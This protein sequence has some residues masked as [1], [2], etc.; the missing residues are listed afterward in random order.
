MT[1]EQK[2]AQRIYDRM[3]GFRVTNVHRKKC[4]RVCIEEILKYINNSEEFMP[5]LKIIF[6][7]K[8]LLELEK[9]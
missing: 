5:Q 1:E 3:K 6:Y 7:D 2:E 8:V 4:A 9:L